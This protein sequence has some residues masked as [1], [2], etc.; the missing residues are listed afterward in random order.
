MNRL[1]VWTLIASLPSSDSP[2]IAYR[3]IGDVATVM[4]TILRE[5][6]DGSDPERLAKAAIDGMLAELDP[7]SR[8]V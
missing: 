2:E 5:H 7:W 1:A 6:V 4:G 3:A 8:R